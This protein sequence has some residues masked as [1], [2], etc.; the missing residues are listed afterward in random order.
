M[1][2]IQFVPCSAELLFDI[3]C[4]Y[5]LMII[6]PVI[7]HIKVHQRMDSEEKPKEAKCQKKNFTA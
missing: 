2:C 6:S 5:R 1:I 7:G 3:E 4:D